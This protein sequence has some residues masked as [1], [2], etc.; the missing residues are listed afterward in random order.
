MHEDLSWLLPGR[1]GTPAEVV[2]RIQFICQHQPDLFA[3][4]LLLV[5]SHQG[6]PR[7]ILAAA[8][9]Q[10]RHDLDDLSREDVA[11][12]LTAVLNGGRDGFEAVLR[13]R[14]KSARKSG[15]LGAW[16]KD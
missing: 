15:G 8:V 5:A 16:V 13:A 11:G 9:K 2:P 10:C 7:E 6:L 1:H 14:R 12:L 4:L 3:A